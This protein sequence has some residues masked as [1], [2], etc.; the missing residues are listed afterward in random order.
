MKHPL[1]S[2][3]MSEPIT[4][5]KPPSDQPFQ[6]DSSGYAA[7]GLFRRILDASPDAVIISD[8]TGRVVWVNER[9][10]TLFG[11]EPAEILGQNIDLLV[12][13]GY[14]HDHRGHRRE[15]LSHAYARPM[16]A[17]P[18]LRARRKDGVLVPVEI[19]LSPI[20]TESGLLIS[21]TI[22][23]VTVQHGQEEALRAGER[24]FRA[25][26]D[27]MFQFI[28]LMK[29]DGTL[30]E[31]NQAALQ[32]A[33]LK[34]EDVIGKPFWECHWWSLTPE[35]AATLRQAVEQAAAGTFVRYVV[36]VR[37]AGDAI[38]TIDFSLKP[39]FNDQGEVELLIPE[40]RNITEQVNAQKAQHESEQLFRSAFSYAAIAKAI[41]SWDG[42]I[43]EVNRSL[44]DLL[45]STEDRLLRRSI[46]DITPEEDV[47]REA[48]QMQRL[49][50]GEIESYR[51]EGRFLRSDERLVWVLKNWSVVRAADGGIRYLILQ[52]QDVS[53]QKRAEHALRHREQQLSRAQEI[54]NLGSWEWRPDSNDVYWSDQL[55]RIYGLH[56][57]EAVT[58]DRYMGMVHPEDRARVKA[59]IEAVLHSRQPFSFYE[60]II[61]TDGQERM[62]YTRGEVATGEDG[63]YFLT[64]V[65]HDL[66]EVRKAER[67]LV[68]ANLTLRQRNRELQDFAY[69]ASHDLQEPLRKLRAFADLLGS[70]YREVLDDTGLDY[71]DRLQSAAARISALISDLLAFSRIMTHGKAFERVDLNEVMKRVLAELNPLVMQARADIRIAPL[72]SIEADALQM[73]QLF[74]H[75][76]ENAVKFRKPD[77][78]PRITVSAARTEVQHASGQATEQAVQIT[79][80][81]N[82]IGFDEKY[83][84]RIFTPFQ[85]L[86]GSDG[87]EG[88]GMGLAI[89]RRIV[90]RHHGAIHATSRPDE[91][92]RFI[93]TLPLRRPADQG[94]G[95]AAPDDALPLD[96]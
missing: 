47:R 54:A 59:A 90:E 2:R 64:G 40:G 69:V 63:A 52:A 1:L 22:R 43:I 9:V 7:A 88:T 75:L 53:E 12:P 30:I 66:T 67:E 95:P 32:F 77:E 37:G 29:P 81:D 27:S 17:G 68:R 91:G 25:I 36:D 58:F 15:Y 92:S 84:D 34:G 87:F 24:R 85:R 33:N 4:G 13:E 16:G 21:S 65:C 35:T 8:E 38:A 72:P 11:Y 76:I 45:C 44:A 74:C 71:L 55:Y 70:E 94:A 82:G 93:V 28:G 83:L 79:V 49:H 46:Y 6:E 86:H 14:R 18:S 56:P 19:S 3:T 89:S 39:I 10:Q 62:L 5:L 50:T 60:R 73:K 41:V 51:A 57:G 26:F 31:A 42:R 78:S 48:V 96:A 61:R 23:D 20:Q 80:Q